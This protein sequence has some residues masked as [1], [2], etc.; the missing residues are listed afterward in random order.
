LRQV[1][2]IGPRCARHRR[3]CSAYPSPRRRRGVCLGRCDAKPSARH[4][5]PRDRAQSGSPLP[6]RAA[7]AHTSAA[8]TGTWS[9]STSGRRLAAR[10][11]LHAAVVRDHDG[12][13]PSARSLKAV[14]FAGTLRDKETP[15]SRGA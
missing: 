2:T 9:H 12:R 8:V 7:L 3:D 14:T 10:D 5:R 1:V 13:R 4:A 6:R 11:E 15:Y